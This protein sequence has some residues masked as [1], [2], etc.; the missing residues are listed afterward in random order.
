MF[1]NY[2][3]VKRFSRMFNRFAEKAR[4]QV[5]HTKKIDISGKDTV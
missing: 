4:K 1:G 5:K 2:I 3:E